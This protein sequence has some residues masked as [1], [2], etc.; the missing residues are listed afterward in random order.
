M[1]TDLDWKEVMIGVSPER[2]ILTQG[3]SQ[4]KRLQYC[5]KHIGAITINKSQG[6]ILSSG[7]AIE[8]TEQ[9]FPWEKGQIVVALRRTPNSI[10][11]I[12]VGEK[13]YAIKCRT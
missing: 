10:S 12:I 1:L 7:I 4:A 5:L 3:G 13:M 2:I 9:Y 11:T 6:E 8:I